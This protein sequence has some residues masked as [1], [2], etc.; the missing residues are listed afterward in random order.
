MRDKKTVE[1]STGKEK[2]EIEV[3]DSILKRAWGL[4]RRTE[5]KMLF[6]FRR[7]T[8]ARIDM[9]LLS[10][11]LNLYFIS[12]DKKVLEIQEAQPW[13]WDPRTWKT[14]SPDTSYRYLI[15][16]FEDLNIEEG[17]TLEFEI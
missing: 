12:S 7:D 17:Q 9:M 8:R 3:A 1:V 11:P 2:L 14:Y 4:S 13:T 16:S 10:K 5:G 6:S 15:E